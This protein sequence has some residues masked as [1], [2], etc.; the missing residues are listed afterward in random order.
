MERGYSIMKK[1][2]QSIGNG[3]SCVYEK[4]SM[5]FRRLFDSI[6]NLWYWL[7][8]I[9]GDRNWDFHYL[10]L[11][12]RH[13]VEAMEK[14]IKEEGHIAEADVIA[15]EMRICIEA[16]DRLIADDYETP[17]FLFH[18]EKWGEIDMRFEGSR[19]FIDRKNAVTEEEIEQE[20]KE[21]KVCMD[22][23][24][25]NRE[26]DRDGLFHSMGMYIDNWWD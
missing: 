11:M 22:R 1:I 8:I 25:K 4:V 18:D 17:A 23:A 6:H 24:V 21:W 7:P 10:Y 12:L 13:K 15:L 9:W 14:Y 20:K 5:R 2:I 16:L 26:E 19:M 3:I